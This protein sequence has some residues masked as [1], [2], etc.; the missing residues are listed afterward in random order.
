[1][2][3]TGRHGVAR[4]AAQLLAGLLCGIAASA[5]DLRP[6]APESRAEFFIEKLIHEPQATDE[7]RSVTRLEEGQSPDS[8]ANDPRTR[9]ALAYLRARERLDAKFG[10]HIAGT[11]RPAPDT[12]VVNV[13]VSENV[14]ALNAGAVVRFQVELQK[15]EDAWLVTRLR[16]D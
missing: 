6:S 7:L 10:L 12:R 3:K 15:Q 9:N 11:K 13:V 14:T 16:S 4:C 8:L 2:M 1:M 5:C